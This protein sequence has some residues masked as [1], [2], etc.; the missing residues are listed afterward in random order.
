MATEEKVELS[1]Q[2][3]LTTTDVTATTETTEG[4]APVEVVKKQKWWFKKVS[5]MLFFARG[6]LSILIK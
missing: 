1:E 2:T 4:Q 3:P 5:L 6:K